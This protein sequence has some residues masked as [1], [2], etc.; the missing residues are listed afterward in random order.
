MA[1]GGWLRVAG[2]C[3]L[4]VAGGRGTRVYLAGVSGWCM[5]LAGMAGGDWLV[6]MSGMAKGVLLLWRAGVH[7]WCG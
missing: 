5:W 1:E 4:G 6:W 2:W 7:G 3:G